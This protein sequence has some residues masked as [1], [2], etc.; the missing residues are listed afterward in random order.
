MDQRASA[1]G[2]E[3]GP[4]TAHLAASAPGEEGAACLVDALD[5]ANPWRRMGEAYVGLDPEGVV[6]DRRNGRAYVACSRSNSVAVVDLADMTR[7]A[8][9]SVG[10]EPIDIV[11]DDVSGLI[12]TAD[13]RSNQLSV[14]DPRAGDRVVSTIEVGL[15]PSGLGIDTVG[16]RLYVGNAGGASV[17]VLDLDTLEVVATVTAEFGAGAVAVDGGRQ[18]AYCVNFLAGSVTVIDT[19]TYEPVGRLEVGAGPCAVAVHPARPEVYVV[20][21]VEGTV[22][23]I[24]AAAAETPATITGTLAAGQAPVG[25]AA[26]PRGDRLYVSNR[27]DGTLSVVSTDGHEMIRVP[28]GEAPGGVS[29]HP[30]DDRRVLVA[31][32]GS[33]TLTVL[34]DELDGSA[35]GSGSRPRAAHPLVGKQLPAFALPD[36]RTGH[37]HESREWSERKYILNFFASW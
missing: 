4:P 28:V 22:T 14:I 33:G 34:V 12:I 6:V 32:A 24:V 9:I 2:G 17:S 26:S 31:D 30:D 15:Y 16:R 27:G 35:H 10:I 23:R 19:Q 37:L 36:L 11:T 18:R 21:S 29:V 25:L 8:E 3:D 7:V 13:A 5:E 1:S 20:N